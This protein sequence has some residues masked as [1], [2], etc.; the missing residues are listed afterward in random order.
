[1]TDKGFSGT[2][3]PCDSQARALLTFPQ[4]WTVSARKSPSAGAPAPDP[5]ESTAS[6]A[7]TSGTV[8][9][10]SVVRRVSSEALLDSAPGDPGSP[11]VGRVWAFPAHGSARTNDARGAKNRWRGS[12][13]EHHARLRLCA[14]GGAPTVSSEADRAAAGLTYRGADAARARGGLLSV[15]RSH[16]RTDSPGARVSRGAP[17]SPKRLK[18]TLVDDLS[19][20]LQHTPT[21]CL[22]PATI[23]AAG[24][25]EP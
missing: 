4:R 25:E 22:P 16:C 18:A 5:I 6:C 20:D 15:V 21:G 8:A 10:R 9:P 17:V 12:H 14:N 2:G 19:S 3:S 1:M 13:H 7:F 24:H 23:S 11:V